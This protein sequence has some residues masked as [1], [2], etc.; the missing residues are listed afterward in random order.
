MY[1]P[2][3]TEQETIINFNQDEQTASI[4]THSKKWQRHLEQKLGL[5]PVKDYGDGGKEYELPK[6]LLCLPRA[7]RT[8][9]PEKRAQLSE[10]M[11]RIHQSKRSSHDNTP[12]ETL[13]RV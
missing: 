10:R 1:R 6:K 5:T 9:S 13:A 8:I 11:R 12:K 3:K 4:Y 2:T 7:P